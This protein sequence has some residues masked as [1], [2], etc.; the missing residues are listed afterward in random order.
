MRL[1]HNVR[2]FFDLDQNG[3]TGNLFSFHCEYMDYLDNNNYYDVSEIR[4]IK[5][6]I[7][8]LLF[9][10]PMI[11]KK[12]KRLEPHQLTPSATLPLRPRMPKQC[13][14]ERTSAALTSPH[15]TRAMQEATGLKI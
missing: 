3:T 2:L 10:S 9:D 6:Q 4:L 8:I 7:L 13:R 15:A 5:S 12:M 11:N 1:D 14:M